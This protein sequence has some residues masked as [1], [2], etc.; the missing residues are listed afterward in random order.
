M[1]QANFLS[2]LARIV[3]SLCMG[4]LPL[5]LQANANFTAISS[6]EKASNAGGT[7][8]P[9]KPKKAKKAKAPQPPTT[10]S[11][12]E[13]KS[14]RDKRLLRECRGKTNAGACEGYAS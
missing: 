8:Q 14:E 7:S 6:A 12:G 5:A 10:P 9:A 2:T 11:T 1:A 4:A 13:N 3:L